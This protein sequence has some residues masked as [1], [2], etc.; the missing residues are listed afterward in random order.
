VRTHGGIKFGTP[1]SYNMKRNT[2]QYVA[3]RGLVLQVVDMSDGAATRTSVRRHLLIDCHAHGLH[4]SYVKRN[5]LAALGALIRDGSIV[6]TFAL[7][8]GDPV[9]AG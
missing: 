9:S 7:A 1:G 6:I 8:T 2:K 3:L 5:W 4:A